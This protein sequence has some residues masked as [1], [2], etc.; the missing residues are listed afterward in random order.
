VRFKEGALVS[1]RKY[2]AIILFPATSI[3]LL[4]WI[5]GSFAPPAFAVSLSTLTEP[6]K[7]ALSFT[8]DLAKLFTGFAISLIGVV[9]FYLK[10]DRDVNEIRTRY[11]TVL[12]VVTIVA[13]V[14]SVFF[15]H[16][17][18]AKLRGQLV[19][20]ILD[21]EASEL[22][23]PERLQYVFFLA[24]LIWSGMLV[25]DRELAKPEEAG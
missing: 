23:W 3:A 15:G 16:L 5:E 19:T 21:L 2:L 14:L 22:V 24:S 1:V 10:L 11:T 25:V 6:Q 4:V 13:A 12:V 9:G 8:Q 18:M 17:W 20:N 7:Q